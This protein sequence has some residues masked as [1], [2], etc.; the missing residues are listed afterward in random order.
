MK[1]QDAE[2]DAR[3]D[4]L[5]EHL[6]SRGLNG[7]V[8]FENAYVLYYTGFAFI[9][10]ERPAALVVNAAGER[11]MFVP[12]L[13]R[14]HAQANATVQHVADYPEYPSEHHPMEALSRLLDEM[15]VRGSIGAD[16]DGY[17]WILGYRGP[18]LT[19]LTGTA[20]ERVAAFVEDQMA[21]KSDAEVRLIRESAKWGNL[22]HVL[23]QRYTRVGLTETEVS[24]RA[25]TEATLAMLDAI[26][27]LYRAQSMFSDGAEAGYRGQIG[28]NAAIPHA[29]ANN[30]VFHEGD[31]LVTGAGA[32]V[33]GY[34]SELERTMV[35]G[36][37]SAQQRELFD[38]MVA[39]Q[40]T[41]LEAMKPGA[42]CSDVDRAVRAYYDEHGLWDY[43]KHHVGH[44]IGLRYHE[45]PFLDIGDDTELQPG[46]VF[47]VEPGLYAAG[48]GGFR[49]SDT[50]VVTDEGIEFL[51]YYPRDLESLTLPA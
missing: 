5:V 18:T 21:I 41:A 40:D 30:I 9:P 12:R 36:E 48:V 16:D 19:E 2:Y 29:L 1:I 45:G 17:P 39:L 46:M 24:R 43:W 23:L 14:E 7:V 42:R 44:A 11:G 15:G 4:A 31:V 28:R 13:E 37:P 3:S 47:T 25:S 8:L 33:W 20:P 26:G 49:H 50:V 51:T 32:P 10:T 35:I 38:H 6:R 27:P 34:H 22:A